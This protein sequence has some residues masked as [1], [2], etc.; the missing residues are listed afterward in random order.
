MGIDL[1]GTVV[2]SREVRWSCCRRWISM[3]VTSQRLRLRYSSFDSAPTACMPRSDTM[4]PS[5]LRHTS[6]EGR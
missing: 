5:R 4:H 6:W 1:V 3:S 2:C